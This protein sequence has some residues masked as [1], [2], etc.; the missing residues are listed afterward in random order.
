MLHHTY[1]NNYDVL[2]ERDNDWE[3][4]GFVVYERMIHNDVLDGA[5]ADTRIKDDPLD[6]WKRHRVDG[7]MALAYHPWVLETLYEL[8]G[9]SAFPFQTL[10]FEVSPAIG[11]HADTIHFNTEPTGWMCG[12]WIALEDVTLDNGPLQYYPRSHKLPVVTFESIGLTPAKD[13]NILHHNLGVYTG[14]LENRNRENDWKPQTLLCRRGTILIWH[15][16]LM[17]KSMQ[18]KPGTTRASQVTHYYFNKPN[19]SYTVPAF[20][21]IHEKNDA[22]ALERFRN[23]NVML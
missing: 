1:M 14:W 5:L 2:K 22:R 23:G 8:Y 3:N 7:I 21:K 20:G 19:I 12:V 16:N 11:L 9:V 17:H 18:P 13:R 4:N 15:A 6:R 10:N